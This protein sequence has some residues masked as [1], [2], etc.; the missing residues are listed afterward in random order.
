MALKNVELYQVDRD[1]SITNFCARYLAKNSRVKVRIPQE[2][3]SPAVLVKPQVPAERVNN[4]SA[5]KLVTVIEQTFVPLNR[6]HS[7]HAQLSAYTANAGASSTGGTDCD[8]IVNLGVEYR[9]VNP[10][11]VA[12]EE[13]SV[14][15]AE[16]VF[17]DVI[18]NRRQ[19][20]PGYYGGV[21]LRS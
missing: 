16:A 14:D 4:A 2:L 9:D 19:G 8:D 15:A 12:K 20:S 13:F 10:P 21:P 11:S 3:K 17:R 6:G 1:I 7:Q 18:A 5:K